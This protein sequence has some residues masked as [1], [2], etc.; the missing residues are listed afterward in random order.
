M[1]YYNQ[2]GVLLYS[3]RCITTIYC[4]LLG[5]PLPLP[6]PPLT[7]TKLHT[8]LSAAVTHHHTHTHSTANTPSTSPA[9]SLHLY[10]TS[11]L[12]LHTHPLPSS[13]LP[14]YLPSPLL[15]P[16]PPSYLS[17]SISIPSP[18]NLYTIYTV[19]INSQQSTPI[20]QTPQGTPHHTSSPK[21]SPST[22]QISHP[23]LPIPP[24]PP[25]LKKN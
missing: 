2:L 22:T 4:N 13:F 23:P 9:Q 3:T 20:T 5:S 16:P 10:C 14:S 6:P 15:P 8:H 11:P 17:H 24:P 18:Y 25:P 19:T 21:G 12:P 7:L 1:Y